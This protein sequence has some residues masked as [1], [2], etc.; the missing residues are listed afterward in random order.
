MGSNNFFRKFIV[1]I[2][3]K[4]EQHFELK[5]EKTLIKSLRAYIIKMTYFKCFVLKG[6]VFAVR[7]S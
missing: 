7:S 1:S 2:T 6:K 5:K 4:A 3:H